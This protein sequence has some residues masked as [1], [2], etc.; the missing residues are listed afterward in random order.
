MWSEG[1]SV[2]GAG[3]LALWLAGWLGVSGWRAGQGLITLF[4]PQRE[5]TYAKTL[6]QPAW[7]R[8]VTHLLI[9][10]SHFLTDIFFLGGGVPSMM[11]DMN[12]KNVPCYF[13]TIF[14]L[15]TISIIFLIHSSEVFIPH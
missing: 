7:M 4:S 14:I 1:R 15:F 3:W 10:I 12:W 9:L 6:H 11:M 13:F 2:T 5:N 8:L